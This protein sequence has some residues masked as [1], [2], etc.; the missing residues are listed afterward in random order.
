MNVDINS[1][2]LFINLKFEEL[3]SYNYNVLILFDVK[4]FFFMG[5]TWYHQTYELRY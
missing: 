5:D 4:K 3:N 1:K 2:V